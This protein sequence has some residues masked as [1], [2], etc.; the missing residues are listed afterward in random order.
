MLRH[1]PPEV[2]FEVGKPVSSAEFHHEN[3]FQGASERGLRDEETVAQ[4]R[5]GNFEEGDFKL[6]QRHYAGEYGGGGV[7]CIRRLGGSF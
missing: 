2:R 3:G 4:M 7:G 6:G 5:F 1:R